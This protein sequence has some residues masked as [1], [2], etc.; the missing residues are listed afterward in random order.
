MTN[1]ILVHLF[2]NENAGDEKHDKKLLCAQIAAAGFECR[3]SSTKGWGWKTIKDDVD[4]IAVAG[5]DGTVRKVAEILLERNASEKDFPIALLPLGTANNI[6]RTLNI[7]GETNEIVR[8]WKQGKCKKFDVGKIIAGKKNEFFLESFG[9]GLFPELMQLM[10]KAEKS[11]SDESEKKLQVA[12]EMMYRLTLSENAKNCTLTINEKDYSGKYLLVEAMNTGSIG[13]NIF[14]SPDADPG[15]G[16][17]EIVLVE[18]KERADFA[19][20]LLQ[21]VENNNNRNYPFK[22][23][24]AKSM[25]LAFNDS[26]AHADDELMEI[27]STSLIQVELMPGLLEFIIPA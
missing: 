21:K 2:H 27:K 6:S 24:R 7:E 1:A 14:L 10:K 19:D 26:R 15:D 16:E 8:G 12:M 5:G 20:Y 18:E 3:A 17:F 4:F 23:I 11:I 13:P 22:T 25:E 9:A